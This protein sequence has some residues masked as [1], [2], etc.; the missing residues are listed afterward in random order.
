M[1]NIAMASVAWTGVIMACFMVMLTDQIDLNSSS[2]TNSIDFRWILP[3]IMV[4]LLA[5]V[6]AGIAIRN[7]NSL[8]PSRI[9]TVILLGIYLP[10]AV[11]FY[12]LQIHYQWILATVACTILLTQ[13]L[14]TSS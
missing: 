13:P 10:L 4:A 12:G 11:L 8:P 5:A 7:R 2:K 1:L 14:S 3:M 9:F 6:E